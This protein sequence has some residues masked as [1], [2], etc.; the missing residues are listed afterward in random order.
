MKPEEGFDNHVNS[1]GEVIASPGMTNFVVEN[2][3]ELFGRQPVRDAF[4][5]EYYR[6]EKAEDARFQT[7][8][9]QSRRR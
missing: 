5:N 1:G 8:F 2:G 4:W 9:T 7:A 3:L 6:P